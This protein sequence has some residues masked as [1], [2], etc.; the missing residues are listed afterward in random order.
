MSGRQGIEMALPPQ[1]ETTTIW[2]A[3]DLNSRQA[4]CKLDRNL[5]GVAPAALRMRRL[6]AVASS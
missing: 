2:E 3:D 5:L 1:T 4:V 6:N